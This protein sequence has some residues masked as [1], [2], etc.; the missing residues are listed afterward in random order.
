V[1]LIYQ[2]HHGSLSIEKER[3]LLI[4]LHIPGLASDSGGPSRSVLQLAESLNNLDETRVRL[5]SQHLTDQ[6]SLVP[7]GLESFISSKAT[8]K[9][10]LFF[11][12]AG[13]RGLKMAW[14]DKQPDIVHIN[15]LWHLF[16]HWSAVQAKSRKIPF[17]IQTHGMLTKWALNWHPRR[18][19]IA[20]FLYQNNDLRFA[21]GFVATSMQ[22]AQS[23]RDFGL[24][25]PIAIIP[26]GIVLPDYSLFNFGELLGGIK[27]KKVLF[28]GRIHPVKG[29]ENLLEAWA[30]VAIEGWTLQIAGP[31]DRSYI[32]SLLH[33]AKKM[34]IQH[35][36]EF[37]GP[38]TDAHKPDLFSKADL[39]VLPSFSENFGVVVA[40][41]L[42]Y[43]L[44]V[45]TTTGTPWAELHDYQSGWCVKP[46]VEGLSYAL[47]EAMVNDQNL[48][49]SMRRNAISHAKNFQWDSL[50][51]QMRDFYSALLQDRPF[52]KNVIID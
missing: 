25:Q 47:N 40:E 46:T 30:K 20:S 41:A 42:S 13:C 14:L 32:N 39:L 1:V 28:L 8:S 51:R 33:C 34:G 22:E 3:V 15:G 43:G 18:K 52:P 26:N 21:S 31:G 17:I 7:L 4:D 9:V 10:D 24:S 19:K 5:I 44:P 45:I 23:I 49:A 50:A 27:S 36:V 6:Q 12:L 38:V 29:L 37:L 35:E 2:R 11:G 48:Y 16:C